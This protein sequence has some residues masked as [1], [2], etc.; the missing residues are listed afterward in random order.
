[1]VAVKSL[2]SGCSQQLLASWKKEIEI[3]KTLYHENIVK[4][5][6]EKIVQ[7]IMEYVPLGSLRD[8]LPKHNVSLAH[9]LL[10]AQQICEVTFPPSPGGSSD[11]PPQKWL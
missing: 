6:G 5:K 2:K 7:L 8:Y 10:F 3:L 9:I 4:Y 1:M 11:P